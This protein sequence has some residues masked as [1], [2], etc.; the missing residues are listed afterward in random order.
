MTTSPIQ[1]PAFAIVT[2]FEKSGQVDYGAMGEYLAFLQSEGATDL[3]VNGTT[4]E[5][6]SLTQE[7]RQEVLEFVRGRWRGRL[8]ANVSDTAQRNV[9]T[10]V[11]HANKVADAL[12][13]LPPFYYASPSA[14]GVHDFYAGILT[15]C[16][17]PV[18]LY[19]FPRHTQAPL[20]PELVARLRKEFPIVVGVKD[21]S[22][23]MDN[24]L[25]TMAAS[26]GIQVFF[27]GD[28]R[29]LEALEKGLHG[30]STGAGNPLAARLVGVKAALDKKKRAAAEKHQAALA[31]WTQWRKTLVLDEVAIVKAALAARITG[32]PTRTRPPLVAA[33][34]EAIKQ[35][36]DKVRGLVKG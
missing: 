29:S 16:D 22:G 19:N 1:S 25:A 10:H 8:V 2:P 3:I 26:P 6:P 24:A 27:G 9:H 12:L 11:H 20:A 36:G 7:E 17:K 34:A 31:E 23:D 18:Y 13:L 21:S 32:F 30:S 15:R 14:E 33:T 5:F 4:G 35:I 28:N